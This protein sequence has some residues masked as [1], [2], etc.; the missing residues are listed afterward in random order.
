MHVSGTLARRLGAVAGA[1][2]AAAAIAAPVVNASGNRT[3]G[4]MRM[5]DAASADGAMPY[6]N[7]KLPIRQRV[8]DLVSRMTLAEK[9]G[10]DDAGRPR[11]RGHRHIEDHDRQPRQPSV[12]RRLGA[13]AEHADG[14][15]G[16]GRPLSA[17]G[18][19]DAAAHPGH[20]R[21]RHR[22]RGWKYGRGHGVPAQHRPRRDS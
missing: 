10:R 17:R 6:Q 18:A 19:G 7:P 16:H 14:V 11:Q 20:L 4:T 2:L 3:T 21:H 13:D 8:Q 9:I 15:G 5:P 12:R 22:P 1:G